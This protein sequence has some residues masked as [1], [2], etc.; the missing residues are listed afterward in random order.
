MKHYNIDI[1]YHPGKVN[2]VVDALSGKTTH[3]S[4][5]I[6]REPREHTDFELV[7]ITIEGIKAQ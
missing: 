7:G 2:V 5:L 1:Q 3:S 4:E 6:M